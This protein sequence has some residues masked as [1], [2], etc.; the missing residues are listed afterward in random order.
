VPR[1]NVFGLLLCGCERYFAPIFES[2]G[3][4][5]IESDFEVFTY[6][7]HVKAI[8]REEKGKVGFDRYKVFGTRFE[9]CFYVVNVC[10]D[11]IE[12]GFECCDIV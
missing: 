5:R 8:T 4:T 11:F 10:A 9:F 7:F 1:D 6:V 12:V 2:D 3:I